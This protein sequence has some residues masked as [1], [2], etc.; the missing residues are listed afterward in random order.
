MEPI[1][2]LYFLTAGM[3]SEITIDDS[4]QR[5]EVG[6]V[7]NEGLAGVPAILGVDQSPHR[8]F[9]ETDGSAFVIGTERL[10]D[11]ARKNARLMSILLRYVHVS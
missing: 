2:K 1:T 11:P 5:I 7:G 10:M 9:M 6:C 3:S 8:S 4:G